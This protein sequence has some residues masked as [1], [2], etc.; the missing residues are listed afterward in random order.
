[1]PA[2]NLVCVLGPIFVCSLAL[3]CLLL[4]R[5]LKSSPVGSLTSTLSSEIPALGLQ[6]GEGTTRVMYPASVADASALLERR[7]WGAE[8]LLFFLPPSAFLSLLVP[9]RNRA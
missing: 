3:F 2:V 9:P 7:I 6:V 8:G 4:N 1:M 5:F